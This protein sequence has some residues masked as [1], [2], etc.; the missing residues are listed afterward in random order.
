MGLVWTFIEDPAFERPVAT[1]WRQTPEQVAQQEAQK[2]PWEVRHWPEF[3]AMLVR[4]LD[5][6]PQTASYFLDEFRLLED[7]LGSSTA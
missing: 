1:I 7:K 3:K 5:R 6:F 2:L 4:V